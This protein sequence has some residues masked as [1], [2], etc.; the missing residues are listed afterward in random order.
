MTNPS[1]KRK[2]GNNIIWLAADKLV[3]ISVGIYIIAETAKHLGI[4]D[5]GT[6]NYVIAFTGMLSAIYTL[7]MENILVRDLSKNDENQNVIISS[8]IIIRIFGSLIFCITSITFAYILHTNDKQL[9]TLVG[10]AALA[11]LFQFTDVIGYQLQS[12]LKSRYNVIIRNIAFFSISAAK[13]VAISQGASVKLFVALL[14]VES[15]I[16]AIGFIIL[17]RVKT[18]NIFVYRDLLVTSKQILKETW[19]AAL[20]F[21][22]YSVYSKSDQVML[23]L[24]TNPEE[25]AYYSTA[26]KFNDIFLTFALMV[27]ASV[28]PIISR[29]HDTNNSKFFKIY[30]QLTSVFSWGSIICIPIVYF[31]SPYVISAIFGNEYSKSSTILSI[32]MIGFFFTANGIL[33]SSYLTIIKKQRIILYTSA[34]S[35]VANIIFNYYL[36]PEWG[37]TGAAVG[38]VMTHAL[39]LLILN[40]IFSETRSLFTLQIKSLN[41]TVIVDICKTQLAKQTNSN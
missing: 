40:L 7:G 37:S 35:A 1:I 16:S 20:S 28:F 11:S 25:V 17:Y 3:K 21:L 24:M 5:F 2:I 14:A 19:P 36:I 27:T 38:T 10:I 41:P 32:L 6:L 22:A 9:I 8:G 26:Y 15:A 13:L 33:R 12:Q 4:K 29:L 39:S 30:L 31:A 23:G 18:R 34:F